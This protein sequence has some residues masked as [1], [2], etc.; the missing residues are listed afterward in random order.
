MIKQT[1]APR[2]LFGLVA[3]FGVLLF[4][5]VALDIPVVG[6]AEARVGRPMSPT[7]VAGV[8]RR[9]TRRAIR[10]T[11]VYIDTLPRRCTTVIVDGSQLHHCSGTYYEPRGRRYVVVIID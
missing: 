2:S 10:R 6:E 9:T 11:T 8:A 5:G 1:R 7:S 4:G 3:A